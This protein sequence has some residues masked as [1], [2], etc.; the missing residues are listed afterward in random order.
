MSKI[1][2]IDGTT[3]ISIECAT[4]PTMTDVI[5]DLIKPVLLAAGFQPDTVEEYFK[6]DAA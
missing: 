3:T 2:F 6:E 4:G 5:D 1:I